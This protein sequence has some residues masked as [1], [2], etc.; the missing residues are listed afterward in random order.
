MLA[1]TLAM[2]VVACKK[3]N[4]E[5]GNTGE[6]DCVT[7]AELKDANISGT[8]ISKS[9]NTAGLVKNSK[10]GKGIEGVCVTDGYNYVKTDKNG[11]FQMNR[12]SLARKIYITVPSEYE[13]PLDSKK[14]LPEFFTPGILDKS[15]NYR[16]DFNLTPLS[17]S[18]NEFTL[19]MIGD[20]QCSDN[21]ESVRYRGE[22]VKDVIKTAG[23]V[24]NNTYCVTLGDITFDSTNMWPTMANTMSNIKNGNKYLPFFQCIGNHDHNSLSTDTA[25][26]EM[27]DYN[28]TAKFVE[29]FGPTDYSFDRGNAH[30]IVMDD[31]PVNT[32]GTSSRPNGKTWNYAAGFTDTQYNWFKQDVA[33]VED[34]ANKVGFICLHIPF[35]G[36]TSSTTSGATVNNSRHYGDFLNE[37]QKFKEFHIMIGHTHYQQNYIHSRKCAGGEAIYEHI[38]GSACGAWWASDCNVTGGP[39]GYSVYSVKGANVTNWY[40]KGSH[41]N[42]DYQLR[43]YDG[44]KVFTGT[45]KYEYAWYNAT[46]TWA[47]ITAKGKDVFK[48][49]FVAD[50]FDDDKANWKVEFWQNGAKVGNFTRAAD[51]GL[52]NVTVCAYWFNEK[53]KTTD[54]YASTTASHYWYYVPASKS[55]SGEKNWEVRAVFTVPTNKS[56]VNTYTRNSFTSDY[57]EFEKP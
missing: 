52:S 36:G 8:D 49:A 31:I 5:N 18:E 33:N 50:V 42:A 19:I 41:K 54:T 11:V 43:V 32:I 37:M 47:G 55:P 6:S 29:T 1:T 3:E 57:S 23:N 7:L 17:E 9:I 35:R 14:H 25:D 24:R 46:N 4:P 21:S 12:N 51:G 15:K 39:N 45:K 27:D 44:N 22:T 26:N 40:M 10:T 48:N 2:G 56:Q 53:G 13:I 38:H 28:A 16:A 34:I 30:I 20:P